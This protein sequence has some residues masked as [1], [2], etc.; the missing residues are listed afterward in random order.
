M[1]TPRTKVIKDLSSEKI[2]LITIIY[3]NEI[4][5]LVKE[6]FDEQKDYDVTVELN[7]LELQDNLLIS[8]FFGK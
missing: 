7:E 1:L 8:S 4:E 3:T 5:F 2:P 6:L